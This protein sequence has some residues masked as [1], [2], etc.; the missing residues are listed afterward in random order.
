MIMLD[1]QLNKHIGIKSV[2][3]KTK[4]SEKP[5]I[6]TVRFIFDWGNQDISE[7]NCN[8]Y[9]EL[10]KKNQRN[11]ENKKVIQE[12]PR[13]KK[14]INTNLC[15]GVKIIQVVP[16]KSSSIKSLIMIMALF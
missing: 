6:P 5:S 10:S 8:L 7:T 13:P 12:V 1:Q 14:R 9:V 15:F 11:N 2:L 4:K 3:N 16:I